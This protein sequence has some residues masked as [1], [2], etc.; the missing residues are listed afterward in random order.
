M[1]WID[2]G[3][4]LIR[5]RRSRCLSQSELAARLQ[6]AASTVSRL[7]RGRL[8]PPQDL[9]TRLVQALALSLEL[10]T[11]LQALA[12]HARL[13][14]AA[15]A[16]LGNWEGASHLVDWLAVQRSQISRKEATPT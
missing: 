16:E 3:E 14:H 10:A 11:W 9:C 13:L 12:A 1:D 8:P 7:E 5:L 4:A 2:F 6:V 15:H